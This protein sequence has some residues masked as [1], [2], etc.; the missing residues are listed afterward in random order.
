MFDQLLNNS[1]IRIVKKL[2]DYAAV[3][4]RV[5]ANNIANVETPGFR[6]KDVSFKEEF[7]KA[8]QSGEMESAFKIEPVV[9]EINDLAIKN[10]GNN[11]NLEKEMVELQ[12]N[13]MKFD[14]YTDV[15]RNRYRLI[16][17]L[18]ANLQK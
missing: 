2:Q 14:I 4:Q 1:S 7:V 17:D 15:L 12:K 9:F 5:I 6:A 8:L 16:K 10:D 11:V 13:K 3:K 18:F